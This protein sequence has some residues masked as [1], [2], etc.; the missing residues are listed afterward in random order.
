MLDKRKLN[1]SSSLNKDIIIIIIK[2]LH[3]TLQGKPVLVST[4]DSLA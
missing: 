1:M 3:M 4:V 2:L